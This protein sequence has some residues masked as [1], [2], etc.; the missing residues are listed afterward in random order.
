MANP[1]PL[2]EKLK[3]S[4]SEDIRRQLQRESL[5]DNVQEQSSIIY[6]KCLTFLQDC[7]LAI[8][9]QPLHKYVLPVPSHGHAAANL[10]YFRELAYNIC[11]LA[12]TVND[13]EPRLNTKQRNIYHDV[14][15]SVHCQS[16]RIFFIDTPGSTDKTFLI[17]LLLARVQRDSNISI[18]VASSGITVMLLEGG[19]MAHSAFKLPLNLNNTETPLCNISKQ[20]NMAQILRQCKLIVWDEC[21]MAHRGGIEALHRMLP[22]IRNNSLTGEL[23][24]LLTGDF[25]QTLPVVLQGTCADEVKAS[26]KSSYLWPKVKVLSLRVNMR[27]HLTGD[28]KAGEISCLL[29]A[30]GDGTLHEQDGKVKLMANL[31]HLVTDLKSLTQKVYPDLQNIHMKDTSWFR[32]RAILTSTNDTTNSINDTLLQAFT[33][34]TKTYKSVDSVKVDDAVHYPVDFLHSLNPPGIPQHNLILKIG[35][36]IMLLRNLQP[37]KLCN[38]TRLQVKSLHRNIIE[39]IIFTGCGREE[40]VFIPRIPLIPA[41]IP[42]QFKRL[43]FPVGVCFAMTINKSQ[44]QTLKVVGVDLRHHCFSHGQLY[45]AFSRVSSADSLIILQPEGRTANVVYKEILML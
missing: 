1:L 16:G 37:P 36:P 32:E 31:Y 34:E 14:M 44:G 30:I 29:L 40:M 7:V 5:Q 41:D 45:V 43:Q 11:D 12:K 4:I 26:F 20:S 8:R 13:N 9:G 42:F 24:V 18:A 6:N 15:T 25:R 28:F 2:R 39:A 35:T 3:D 23:T 17:N 21:T 10:N 38:G 19:Q 33:S 22:D 27:V